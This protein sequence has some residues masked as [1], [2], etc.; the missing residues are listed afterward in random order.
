MEDMIL[1]IISGQTPENG[2]FA[3]GPENRRYII[4]KTIERNSFSFD[5]RKICFFLCNNQK[6]I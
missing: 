5:Q 1:S 6:M 2:S 4:K 3:H